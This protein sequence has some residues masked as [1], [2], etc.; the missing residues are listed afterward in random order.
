MSLVRDALRGRR[1]DLLFFFR[2]DAT[3][4]PQDIVSMLGS[5]DKALI[6]QII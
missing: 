3:M 1:K 6:A 4:P 2:E 5:A